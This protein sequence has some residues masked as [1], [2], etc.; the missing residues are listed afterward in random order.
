MRRD[1][2]PVSTILAVILAVYLGINKTLLWP[3]PLLSAADSLNDPRIVRKDSRRCY[4]YSRKD[5]VV[6]CEFVEGHAAEAVNKGLGVVEM[7]MFEN[8][9]HVRHAVEDQESYW[10]AIARL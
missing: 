6:W 4:L 10:G 1:V 8:S 5:G 7:E 2:E 9:S 3:D